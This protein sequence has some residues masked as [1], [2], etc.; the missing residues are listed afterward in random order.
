MQGED[1]RAA[2][3][4][5]RNKLVQEIKSLNHQ[6]KACDTMLASLP[7]A[8]PALLDLRDGPPGTAY[9]RVLSAERPALVTR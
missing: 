5:W 8:D 7:A 3:T 6:L 4:A 2:L 9:F 1:L